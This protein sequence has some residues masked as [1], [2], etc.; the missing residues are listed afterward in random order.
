MKAFILAA[1]IGSR[2]GDITKEQP[3][4]LI[5]VCGK[6]ILEY[7]LDALLANG[8]TDV[9]LVLGYKKEKILAFLESKEKYR[10]M[11]FTF[12]LN[13]EYPTTNSSYSYWQAR[14][15]VGTEPYIHLNCDIVLFAPLIKRLKESAFDNAILVDKKVKLDASMEQV[16]LDGDRV[17]KMDKANLPG[18]MGRG[19]GM[20]KLSPAAVTVMKERVESFILAGDKN[21]HCHGLM[22]HALTK[23][24]FYALDASDLLFREI[25]TQ[26]E[27]REA[28]EIIE[29]YNSQGKF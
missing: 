27:L 4:C 3:K 6:P 26:E 7:Q 20:A 22:R 29:K 18:A 25:N 21:Q 14:S 11:N 28:K 9:A 5:S 2:L 10:T 13:H 17:V 12:A 8:I 19:S 24:P 15:L 23:V 1:G 16:I